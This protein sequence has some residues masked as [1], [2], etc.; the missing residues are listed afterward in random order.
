MQQQQGFCQGNSGSLCPGMASASV[1]KHSNDISWKKPNRML[2]ICGM[3]Q[4]F[5]RLNRGKEA[6]AWRKHICCI[7]VAVKSR[8]LHCTRFHCQDRCLAE[9]GFMSK[10]WC[11]FRIWSLSSFGNNLEFLDPEV[12]FWTPPM[13]N[14]FPAN[15]P[16]SWHWNLRPWLED[17]HRF[18]VEAEW[19]SFE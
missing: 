15:T 6:T 2:R 5:S 19:R 14:W 17:P 4:G 12:D 16:I 8:N 13:V 18:R 11:I 1:G 10:I 7:F 9:F 3:C